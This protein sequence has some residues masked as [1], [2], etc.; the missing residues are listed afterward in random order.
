MIKELS[1]L[2]ALRCLE[3]AARHQSYTLAA[4]ELH[5]SQAAVSQQI[6]L[7][8]DQLNVKLFHRKGRKMVLTAKGKTLARHLSE[9]FHKITEG[10][11]LIRSEPTEGP[12]SVTTT[13]SFASM[14]LIPKLW[15]FYRAHPNISVRVVVS[16]EVED[17]MH[18]DMDIALRYGF[19]EQ[20]SLEQTTLFEDPIVPLCSPQLLKDVDLTKIENITQCWLVNASSSP[21]NSREWEAWFKKVNLAYHPEKLKWLGVSNLDMALSAVMA[22]HGICLG[23]M[24]LAEQYIKTGAL[25]NPLTQSLT[26]GI[27]YSFVHDTASPKLARINVFKQ[28]LIEALEPVL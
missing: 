10:I 27:R 3:V 20:S 7:L 18:G 21:N 15:E 23:S 12:L 5:V 1:Y 25:V 28:W 19:F 14:L 6:R 4:Q 24:K 22:G 16:N 11:R 9:G 2:T 17:L 13:Q 26:P 8:E